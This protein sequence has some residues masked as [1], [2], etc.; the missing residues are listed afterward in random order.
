MNQSKEH[1]CGPVVLWKV[2]HQL[3]IVSQ[4][5]REEKEESN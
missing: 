1:G 3:V 4:V 2:G 5:Q